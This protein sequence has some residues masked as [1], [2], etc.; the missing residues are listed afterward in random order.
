MEGLP[1]RWTEFILG[2]TDERLS[3]GWTDRSL[4][5]FFQHVAELD[6]FRRIALLTHDL[7][8]DN[9]LINR[10]IRSQAGHDILF[11]K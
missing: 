9:G 1:L 3:T 5:Q 6:G 7:G 4:T 10:Y 8:K 2:S 11:E